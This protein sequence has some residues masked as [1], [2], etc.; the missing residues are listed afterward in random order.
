MKEW[1][2]FTP[3]ELK[4]IR[5]NPYVKSATE[6]MI[7]FTVAF[8]EKFW[9]R[10]KEDCIAPANI[11]EELGFD[12]TV[13][14]ETRIAGIVMHLREQMKRD[15]GFRDVRKTP[16]TA[17]PIEEITAGHAVSRLNHRLTYFEQELEFIKKNII[18]DNKARRKK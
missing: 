1:K 14:G 5:A 18:A 4:T 10:Y 17:K 13:I 11:M 6:K 9:H 3:K 8:K 12:I 7:R 2:T 15:G 16:K